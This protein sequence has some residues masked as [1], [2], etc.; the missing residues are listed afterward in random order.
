MHAPPS[1]RSSGTAQAP[2]PRRGPDHIARIARGRISMRSTAACAI[3]S[4]SICNRM[5]SKAGAAFS[6]PR[7]A[8]GRPAR[9][10]GPGRRQAPAGTERPRSFRPRRGLDRLPFLLPRHGKHRVWRFPVSRHE[11]SRRHAGHG[12][13]AARGRQ[14][15]AAISVRAGRVRPDV[16]DQRHRHLDPP[17]PQIRQPRTQGIPA[18][19]DAVRRPSRRC[20]RA[21]NS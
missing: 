1:P 8:G 4:G 6:P 16:S 11:P 15:C 18:A 9:R 20:G 14:I 21:R 19:E 7:R 13:P 5:I 12:P 2:D 10:A 3:Y 17:D